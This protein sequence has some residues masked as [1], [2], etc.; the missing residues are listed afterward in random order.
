MVRIIQSPS[1][2]I[3]ISMFLGVQMYPALNAARL[4]WSGSRNGWSDKRQEWSLCRSR[5]TRCLPGTRDG[6]WTG[7]EYGWNGRREVFVCLCVFGSRGT[8]PAIESSP[9]FP[10][11]SIA[12]LLHLVE[13]FL[14]A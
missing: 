5:S 2:N 4:S 6:F 11:H 12:P 3:A 7:L 9:Y 13:C 8:H 10:H 14:H 1:N